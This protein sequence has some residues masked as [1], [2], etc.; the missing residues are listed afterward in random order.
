MRALRI[1]RRF[2]IGDERE[3][4][5]AAQARRQTPEANLHRRFRRE[6]RVPAKRQSPFIIFGYVRGPDG[7]PVAIGLPVDR[8]VGDR[9]THVLDQGPSRSGKTRL[10]LSVVRKALR[11]PNLRVWTIDPKGDLTE[12]RERILA[13]EAEKAGGERLVARL[14]IVRLFD[15]SAPPPLRLTASEEGVPIAV[16]AASIGTALGEASGAEL[17]SRMGHILHYPAELAV[18]TNRPLTCVLDWLTRPAT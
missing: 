4:A 9:G 1:I 15:R 7:R 6:Y 8:I 17:G 3:L 5:R 2:V 10:A 13:A 11:I 18:E 12:G 16:Q 14:R